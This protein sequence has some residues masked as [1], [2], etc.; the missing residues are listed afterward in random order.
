[1]RNDN[2]GSVTWWWTPDCG[3]LHLET[4][5]VLLD[6]IHCPVHIAEGSD[7]VD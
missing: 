2:P 3:Y 1:M 6:L 5:P 7:D 4:D